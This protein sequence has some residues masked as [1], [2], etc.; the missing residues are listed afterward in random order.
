MVACFPQVSQ[1]WPAATAADSETP[2]VKCFAD[3]FALSTF[4]YLL[5]Q[6]SERLS[7]DRQGL[8]LGLKLSLKLEVCHPTKAVTSCKGFIASEITA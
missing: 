4:D 3:D 5:Q 8:K 7:D 6:P 2:C 1:S